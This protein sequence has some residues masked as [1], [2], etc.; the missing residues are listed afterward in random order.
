MLQSC[1]VY[2]EQI[3]CMIDGELPEPK[4]KALLAHLEQCESCR[5]A[6]AAFSALSS[7]LAK[8]DVSSIDLSSE[9][10][11]QVRQEPAPQTIRRTHHRPSPL[12]ILGIA[13]G[14]A[15]VLFAASRLPLWHQNASTADMSASSALSAEPEFDGSTTEFAKLTPADPDDTSA[16]MADR[17]EQESAEADHSAPSAQLSAALERL[18]PYVADSADQNWLDAMLQLCDIF[19]VTN[20]TEAIPENPEFV[21]TL[22]LT[23][24][25]S[26]CSLSFWQNDNCTWIILADMDHARFTLQG[27]RTVLEYTAPAA[28]D[29]MAAQLPESF[30]LHS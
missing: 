16:A 3:S 7:H 18:S 30:S 21:Y 28:Y 22:S 20:D 12:R 27:D 4:R 11:A 25:A 8:P 15:L 23:E 2:L 17:S 14:L 9:I 24:Q 19:T 13:A 5:N 10:M 1:D 29:W 26:S 6:Y